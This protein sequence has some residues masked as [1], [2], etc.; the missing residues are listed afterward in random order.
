MYFCGFVHHKFHMKEP[1][2]ISHIK[3]CTQC[4]YLSISD[5][6]V[7]PKMDFIH[8][9]PKFSIYMYIHVYCRI[10]PGDIPSACI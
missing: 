4:I 3:A 8:V 6:N 1:R 2:P 7:C 10:A 5:K 9:E